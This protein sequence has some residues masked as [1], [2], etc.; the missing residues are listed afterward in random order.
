MKIQTFI[1]IIL[2]INLL[3]HFDPSFAFTYFPTP[4]FD[5]SMTMRLFWTVGLSF[6]MRGISFFARRLLAPSFKAGE[7][8]LPGTL[9]PYFTLGNFLTDISLFLMG[10]GFVLIRI[11]DFD[12]CLR[13][14]F[15]W[16]LVF[17]IFS[18]FYDLSILP[19]FSAFSIAFLTSYFL[20]A[21]YFAALICSFSCYFFSSIYFATFKYYCLFLS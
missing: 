15:S 21:I 9:A 14:F 18:A 10:S 7:S 16:L 5:S 2:Y 12:F 1:P 20:S 8:L 13:L 17:Y 11:S 19:A 3:S 4:Y 6:L